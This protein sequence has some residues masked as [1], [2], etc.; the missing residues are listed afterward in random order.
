MSEKLLVVLNVA[1]KTIY[2]IA[3]LGKLLAFKVRG[4][5]RFR[6]AKIDAWPASRVKKTAKKPEAPP[7]PQRREGAPK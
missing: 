3:Q 7:R 6:R 1:D 2:T 4:Q 5:R